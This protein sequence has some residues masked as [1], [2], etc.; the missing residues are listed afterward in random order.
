MARS[1]AANLILGPIGQSTPGS[2]IIVDAGGTSSVTFSG[3]NTY[4]GT[5]VV[6]AGTLIVNGTHNGGGAY[7]VA[8]GGTLGGDGTIGSS[9]S[10]TGGRINPGA[11]IGT[12]TASSVSLNGTLSIDLNDGDAN[13]QDVLNVTGSL[14]LSGASLNLNITGALSAPAYI[15]GHYGSL[16]GSPFTT[17]SGTPG[18]YKVDYNYLNGN[19]IALVSA[20]ALVLGDWDR[21]GSLGGSDVAAMLTALTDLNRYKSQ[22]TL[23][24]ANLVTIGDYDG[25]GKVTNRDI[26]PLLDAVALIGGA[27]SAAAVPEPASFL[28]L[29]FGALA[30]FAA[31]RRR[32]V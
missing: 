15:I 3:N 9:V 26:Q 28:L 18:N 31:R 30:L 22:N 8:N 24:E 17:F 14:A 13:I 29:G 23:S 6:N 21:N 7:T 2:G 25:D 27:G 19:Q 5:T 20:P 1:G 16:T 32:K 10:V 4:T 11:T 12:L